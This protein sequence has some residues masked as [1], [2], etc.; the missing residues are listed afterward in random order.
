ML[1]VY[2]RCHGCGV[3]PTGVTICRRRL[4]RD[5]D[6]ATRYRVHVKGHGREAGVALSL[7]VI[8][9]LIE[10][11]VFEAYMRCVAVSSKRLLLIH[12]GNSAKSR[13]P[14]IGAVHVRHRCLIHCLTRET[15]RW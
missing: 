12:P 6:R 7:A 15:P 1:D 8:N 13:D 5:F 11:D 3:S 2:S 10:G 9:Q 4:P 14:R